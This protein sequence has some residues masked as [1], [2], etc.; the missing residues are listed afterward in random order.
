MKAEGDGS[1]GSCHGDG[2][3][4]M[5]ASARPHQLLAQG[6]KGLLLGPVHRHR[7]DLQVCSGGPQGKTLEDGEPQGRGLGGGQLLHQALQRQPIGRTASSSLGLGGDQLIQQGLLTCGGG[8]EAGVAK[9]AGALLMLT[10]GDTHQP[11]PIAQMVLQGPGDAAAQI[12]P[13]GLAC[14]AA[15]S[16]ADEGLAGHLDQI[17]PLHQREQTP[18]GGGSDGIGQ[19]QMLQHQG[20]A[21]TQ[22]R[23]AE[24]G[25]GGS[26]RQDGEEPHPTGRPQRHGK[27]AQHRRAHGP[28]LDTA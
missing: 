19:G 2:Q 27:D 21:G 8:I 6:G 17:F 28:I 9:R 13:S 24:G 15:G 1:S 18:G 23:A 16:R 3:E 25:S 22:G 10:A 11:H 7:A 12:G 26:H 4:P 5:G 14:F 20:I